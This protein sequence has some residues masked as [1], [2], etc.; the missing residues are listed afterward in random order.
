MPNTSPTSTPE[1]DTPSP[2]YPPLG[3]L[4]FMLKMR[5]LLPKWFEST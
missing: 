1:A 3:L 5:L 2:N 4:V